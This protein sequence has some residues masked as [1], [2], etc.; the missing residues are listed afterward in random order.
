MDEL[1]TIV[2][3]GLIAQRPELARRVPPLD[4]QR[5]LMQALM[6]VR[7][8]GPVPA[9]VLDAQDAILRA[10]A[11]ARGVVEVDALPG[12]KADPRL[13]IWLGDITKLRADAIVNAANAQLL[14]CFAPL[15]ACID[16]AIHSA[17][18]MQLRNCC[19]EIMASRGVPEP[20]GTATLTPGFNLPAAHVLHT[21]GPIVDGPVTTDHERG[22]ASSYRACLQAAA[23]AGFGSVAFCS[24]STG[25][26]RFPKPRAA[27]I[28]VET[29]TAF[30][31][32]PS[33]LRRVVFNVFSPADEHFY[34]AL[35][36]EDRTTR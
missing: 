13:A 25:V 12:T 21:V 22:L 7:A 15:H 23:E 14:G 4:D 10:E 30:L 31:A 6:N 9:E 2:V 32:R 5:L 29:V 8:P 19:A 28:A 1:V 16:N 26:F 27:E 33:S 20:T 35:L 11:E 24:I 3:D 34:R 17:A 18:G 36:G